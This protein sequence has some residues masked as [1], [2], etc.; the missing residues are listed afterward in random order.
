MTATHVP[1]DTMRRIVELATRA[2]SVH[3]TQPWRWRA[4]PTSLELYA[5]RSRQLHEGDP[6]GRNLTISCGAALHHAQV[7]A[8][9]LGWAATVTRLPDEGTP[10]LLAVLALEPATPSRH[11]AARLDAIEKR[12]TDRRRFTSWPV[13]DDRLTHLAAQ[14]SSQGARALPLTDVTER[15]HAEMLINR[16]VHLQPGDDPAMVEQRSWIDRGVQDGVPSAV[17]PVPDDLRTRRQSRFAGGL[18]DDIGGDEVEGSD[19]L[20]VLCASDDDPAAWLTAGEGLSA[21][22]LEATIDGMSVVPL[23]Q[24]VEVDETRAAFHLG[25]LGGLARPLVVIRVGWQAI[26]RSELPRTPRR[27]VAEV[28]ELS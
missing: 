17:L 21:L 2:P 7:A 9:A 8:D 12:C 6:D 4:G 18:L 20:I 25:V 14:A 19:G 27:P 11:A 5:D 26:S 23:S 3:N 10:D 24:V 1:P 13:A 16:A 22:W 15:F 28:L